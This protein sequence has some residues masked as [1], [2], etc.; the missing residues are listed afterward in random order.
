MEAPTEELEVVGDSDEYADGDE[1]EQPEVRACR[2]DDADRRRSGERRGGEREE[3]PG[4]DP[5]REGPSV[6][7]IERMSG[8]P[9]AEE[10][11]Q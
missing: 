5:R 3:R 2:D 1:C 9:H 11:R 8:D 4:P 10:E 7:L 6:Q